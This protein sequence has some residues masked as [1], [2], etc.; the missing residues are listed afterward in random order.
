MALLLG[1]DGRGYD[2]ARRLDECGAWRTWLGDAA[3]AAFAHS[4]SSAGT[5]EA[6]LTPSSSTSR[7]HL[8]LQLRARAL[9]FDKASVS[10]FLRSPSSSS[11]SSQA[12]S[13]LNLNYLQ[14]HGD[15]VYFSLEDDREDGAQH[16]MQSRSTFSPGKAN[17]H[18]FE[19]TSIRLMRYNEPEDSNTSQRHSHEE[20]PG[21]WF[22]K[23]AEKYRIR[24]NRFPSGEKEPPK[25]TTEGM[26]NYLRLCSAHKRKRQVFKDDRYVGL[27]EPALDNGT[28]MRSKIAPDAISSID[29]AF[30][31]ELTFPSD[32]IPGSALSQTTGIENQKVEVYGVLDNLPPLVSRSPAMLERFG[33]IPDYQ[34]MGRKYRGKDGSGGAGRPLCQEQA[35]QMTQKVVARFLTNVGFESGTEVSVEVLSE[36][37]G[38]HICKLGRI[39][40]L[41]TDSYKK[42]FTS[43]ELLKM[44]LQVA[45]YSNIGVL[46]EFMKGGNKVLSPQIQQQSHL[47]Q[48]QHQNPLLQYGNQ[49][50]QRPLHPQMNMGLPQN[51]TFQQQQ[52]L[53]HL[54]RRQISSP[55]GSVAMMDKAQ[56][57]MVDVKMENMSEIPID[58]A[59]DTLSK[60]TLQLRQQQQQI[61]MANQYAQSGQQFKQLSSVQVPQLQAQNAY[62]TRTPPVKVEAFHE[63]MSGDSTLKHESE[64]NKLT[65]PPK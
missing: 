8:H 44:F 57:P 63:L 43:V 27:G 7:A 22:K 54:R 52:Q 58:G 5:W 10:L 4:L 35:S 55:R 1:E 26:Y 3:Y 33:I 41:L 12:I 53:Q 28:S 18:S 37:F 65:A 21:T 30:F 50:F 29:E 34:K 15:D 40:K 31:P 23:F 38:G 60:H 61:A 47:Y 16:Q 51:L 56:Q 6:F 24:H 59:F 42:Q 19:R 39:L 64:H 20:L 49:Q 13:N 48:T 11:S 25:R 2:L 46:T 36:I 62:N 17:E 32:C 14:L 45:G 9:L